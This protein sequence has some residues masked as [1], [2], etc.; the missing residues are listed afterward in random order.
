MP[1]GLF[2]TPARLEF[3]VR[4]LPKSDGLRRIAGDRRRLARWWWRACG[5]SVGRGGASVVGQVVGEGG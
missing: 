5:H 1:R 4:G 3:G 2:L